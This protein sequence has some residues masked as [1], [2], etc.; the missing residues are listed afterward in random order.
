MVVWWIL[1]CQ[2]FFARKTNDVFFFSHRV[3][4]H[5]QCPFKINSFN[6][7][8]FTCRCG[9]VMEGSQTILHIKI[10]HVFSCLKTYIWLYYRNNFKS[11]YSLTEHTL[12]Y[13]YSKNT[14]YIW[15]Q[16]FKRLLKVHCYF[17]LYFKDNRE[18]RWHS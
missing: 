8:V 4:F 2:I 11:C 10:T 3:M 14:T 13:N 7:D 17:I 5:L 15:A 18:T 6:K 12:Y 16:L 9:V 1:A